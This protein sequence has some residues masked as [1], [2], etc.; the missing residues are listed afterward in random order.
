MISARG[1]TTNGK[2]AAAAAGSCQGAAG[3]A[4]GV[5]EAGSAGRASPGPR[6]AMRMLEGMS[7]YAAP[8]RPFTVACMD[9][10]H[11]G[12]VDYVAED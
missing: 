4:P 2:L 11:E 9:G 12:I 1:L 5:G 3:L 8:G 10:S 6:G 7:T